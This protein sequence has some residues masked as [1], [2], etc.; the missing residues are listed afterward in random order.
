MP[1]T[2]PTEPIQL[3]DVHLENSISAVV[4]EQAR[5]KSINAFQIMQHVVYRTPSAAHGKM[6]SNGRTKATKCKSGQTNGKKAD[7]SKRKNETNDQ[8]PYARNE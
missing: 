1:F 7:R 4:V 8:T 3:N 5:I 2:N 6:L